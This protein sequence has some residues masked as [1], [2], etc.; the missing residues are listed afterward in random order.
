M[1]LE[2]DA[3]DV[4]TFDSFSTLVD[5]ES[6]AVA[7]EGYVDKPTAFARDWHSRAAYYGIV[8]NHVDAYHT[9][10]DFHR[11]A[12]EYMFAAKG[13][14]ATADELEEITSVY[15]DM[16]PFDDVRPAMATLRDAGYTVGIVS[17]GNPE[18]LESLER[19]A[20]IGDLVAEAVSADEIQR[21]KPA[22]ELYEHAA[23]RFGINTEAICHVA[24]GSVDVMGAKHAGMQAVWCN[25]TDTPPE[26]FGPEPDTA[27]D[28]LADLVERL[29]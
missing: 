24:N 17:N 26:P 22:I 6:T 21:F 16:R 2:T 18:M 9:Y 25:R 14:S 27:V 8:A 11:L 1:T 10:D 15:H 4:V 29:T 3:I 12:L 23:R 5:V 28:G 20:D 13:I 19:R 7:V